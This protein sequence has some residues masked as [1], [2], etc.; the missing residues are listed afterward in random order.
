MSKLK[1]A[2][3]L[4]ILYLQ[5]QLACLGYQ[6]HNGVL[7][8]VPAARTRKLTY[9]LHLLEYLQASL[10]L[11]DDNSLS[12]LKVKKGGSGGAGKN[13]A[14]TTC[15]CFPFMQAVFLKPIN[16]Y[17]GLPLKKWGLCSK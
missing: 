15:S 9:V 4:Y 3:A 6:V 7:E 2:H 11:L 13:H 1:S 12:T 8:V 16:N 10:Q 17:K 5:A 14:L